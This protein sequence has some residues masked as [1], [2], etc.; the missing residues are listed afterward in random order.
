MNENHAIEM[1]DLDDYYD[2]TLVKLSVDN[3]LDNKKS[4]IIDQVPWFYDRTMKVKHMKFVTYNEKHQFYRVLII[5]EEKHNMLMFLTERI[6]TVAEIER[7][8]GSTI[9]DTL[10]IDTTNLKIIDK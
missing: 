4:L 5:Y 2:L 7:L 3:A 9:T 10:Q 6:Q 8:K 1:V